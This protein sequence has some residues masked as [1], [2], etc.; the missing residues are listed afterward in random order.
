MNLGPRLVIKGT[1]MGSLFVCGLLFLITAGVTFPPPQVAKAIEGQAQVVGISAP[2]APEIQA[3]PAQNPPEAG[4]CRVS[5]KFPQKVLQWC[6]L[7]T[8]YAQNQNL[9]PDLVAAVIWQES[10]GNPV[11]YSKSGAVGLMQV[12]PSD[13][14]A[15][16]FQCVGGPCFANRPTTKE[17]KD[18]EYNIK[19]GTRMIAN[20]IK[21]HGDPRE[22]LKAYG[23][24]NVGYYY[25]DKVMS[26]YKQY[27]HD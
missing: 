12:M 14:L 21:K 9:P 13:G 18:P 19:Y 8:Q 11:A 22:A 6:E 7:I 23:P 20:L 15:A 27:G 26:L 1:F 5:K 3:S 16:N 2:A 10:G 4:T 24:M 25:A 17:L